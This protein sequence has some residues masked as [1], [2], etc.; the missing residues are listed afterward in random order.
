MAEQENILTKLGKLFQNQ[1]VVRKTPTG[2]LKVKDIDLSLPKEYTAGSDK[3]WSAQ[4]AWSTMML[5]F[6]VAYPMRLSLEGWLRGFLYG[7]DGPLNAPW[8]FLDTLFFQD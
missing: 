1:I 6:R 8:S 5:P 3:L 4:M 2:Q 7:F